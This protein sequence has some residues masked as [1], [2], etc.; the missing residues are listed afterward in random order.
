MVESTR[1]LLLFL[2]TVYFCCGVRILGWKHWKFGSISLREHH[3]QSKMLPP[4]AHNSTSLHLGI[5]KTF[6]RHKQHKTLISPFHPGTCPSTL[7]PHTIVTRSLPPYFW[8]SASHCSS[9]SETRQLRGVLS[10]ENAFENAAGI[11]YCGILESNKWNSIFWFVKSTLQNITLAS[12]LLEIVSE[13]WA[14]LQFLRQRL[15]S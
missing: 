15:A 11:K 6:R 13:W 12:L 7:L 4:S 9:C 14:I 3:P 8:H 10:C 1:L 5:S 2:E